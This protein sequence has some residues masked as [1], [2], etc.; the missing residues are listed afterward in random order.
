M[1]PNEWIVQV[2]EDDELVGKIDREIAHDK[3]LKCSEYKIWLDRFFNPPHAF[4]DNG[5][6]INS[7]KFD[8]MN[9]LDAIKKITE[10]VGGKIVTRYKMRDAVFARQRYWGEPIPLKH[11]ADGTITVLKE[12]D[13][14]L[15][16]PNVKSYASLS[17]LAAFST[18]G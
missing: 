1:N 7:G 11:N 5:I 4:V 14:P 8:G 15:L 18:S 17:Y 2:N 16:L 9:N 12:K 3:N 10:F 13:L 6:M